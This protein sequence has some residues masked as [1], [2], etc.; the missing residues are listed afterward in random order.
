[1]KK[2][3]IKKPLKIVDSVKQNRKDFFE[4]IKDYNVLQLAIGVVVGSA[5]KDLTNSLAENI[6]MPLIG[7]FSPDGVY[8]N[9]SFSIRGSEFMV[10]KLISSV[11]DFLIVALVVFVVIKKIFRI[12][13]KAK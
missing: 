9:L 3:I 2:N 4:F 1:M 7:I 6:L 8:E 12:D 13:I 10:G 11:I 5:V